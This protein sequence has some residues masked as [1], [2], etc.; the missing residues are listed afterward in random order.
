MLRTRIGMRAIPRVAFLFAGLVL[1]AAG[2]FLLPGLLG[3]GAPRATPTPLPAPSRS[4]GPTLGVVSSPTPGPTFATYVVQAGDTMSKIAAKFSIPLTVLIDANK[5]R[6]P[7]PDKIVAGDTL[8][9]PSALPSS[10]KD[11]TQ[12]SKTPGRSP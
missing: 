8:V 4:P 10:F 1:A 3:I 2:L 9:I 11:A 7:N 12:P 5:D 6:Y